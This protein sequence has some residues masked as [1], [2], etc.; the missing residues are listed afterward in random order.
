VGAFL[1]ARAGQVARDPYNTFDFLMDTSERHGLRS[2]FFF[3][4][5]PTAAGIDGT[6]AL[7]DPPI[8]DL[9]RR[10]NERGHEVGLHASYDS[11]RSAERIELELDGLRAACRGVGFEQS[12]WGVRQHYLRFE[13]PITWRSQAAAGLAYDATVGFADANGFRAGTCREYPVF[14]LDDRRRLDLW[15]RPLTFMDAASREFL[16]GDLD[17]AAERARALVGTCRRHQGGAVL[18]YHNSSLPS[19]R[20][21]DHYRT[22]IEALV[23]DGSANAVG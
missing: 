20:Q 11:F 16:A 23:A 14:D 12:S 9:L 7:S 19:A 18:L 4:A 17:D 8:A 1:D 5:G 22:L 3:L 21:R 15:E 13:A 6:Y 2:T 10:V